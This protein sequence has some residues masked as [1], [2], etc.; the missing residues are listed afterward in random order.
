[1][2]DLPYGLGL[3]DWDQLWDDETVRTVLKAI[4]AINK[5]NAF[6]VAFWVYWRDLGR[7]SDLLEQQGF[8]NVTP[9]V[10]HK[11]GQNKVGPVDVYTSACEFLLIAYTPNATSCKTYF[12]HDPLQRHNII[13]S[14]PL[15]VQ[16]KDSHGNIV[17][18]C[19]KPPAVWNTVL[20]NFVH[21]G[22]RV[23]LLC[24]GAGGDLRAVLQKGLD[25]VALEQDETQYAYLCTLLETWDAVESAK[26]QAERKAEEKAIR[27]ERDRP[28]CEG[29][30][31]Y[32]DSADELSE[33]SKCYAKYCSDT[34]MEQDTG[35]CKVCVGQEN[36]T[37]P[38]LVQS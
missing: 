9:V 23:L 20:D 37:T 28:S 35:V 31:K 4:V 30:G 3:A 5:L 1:M 12:N 27:A 21:P 14:D 25:V 22:G 17:N 18:I 36:G 24:A 26:F 8:K 16:N 15:R 33:C 7:M 32:K 10:W 34:C 13:E 6:V 38:V 2:A 29:C 11:R 19:E